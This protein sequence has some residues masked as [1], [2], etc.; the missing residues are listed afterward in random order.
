MPKK[1]MVFYVVVSAETESTLSRLV[2]WVT[3]QIS[4]LV[5]KSKSTEASVTLYDG[6][7]RR[8]SMIVSGDGLEVPP[9]AIPMS[10]NQPSPF[11]QK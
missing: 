6:D 11:D 4:D 5:M 2:N 10:W 3:H 8:K 1:D 7:G 9:A